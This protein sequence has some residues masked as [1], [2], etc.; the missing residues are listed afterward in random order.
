M[1]IKVRGKRNLEGTIKIKGAK[2]SA[3][4]IIPAAI[5]CDGEVTLHNVPHISDVEILLNILK[6]LDYFIDFKDGTLRIKKTKNFKKIIHNTDTG[7]MRGSYY[8]IGSFLSKYHKITIN[9]SGG[10]NL[11]LRPINYHL[12][13]FERLGVKYSLENNM[14]SLKA[15]SLKGARIDLPFPSVGATINIMLASTKAKGETIITGAAKEPEVIDTANF[16]ISMGAKIEGAGTDTI[17]IIGVKKLSETEYT[18]ASD[19]I[20]AGTFLI[21]GALS[22]GNGIV[23]ENV[24]AS[25]LTSLTDVLKEMGAKMLISPNKIYIRADKPLKATSITTGPYPLFPTDLGPMISVLLTQCHGTSYLTETVFSNRFS[26]VKDLIKM[27]AN[28][29]VNSNLLEINGPVKLEGTEMKAHDLRGAASLILAAAM[30]RKF[31]Y[32]ENIEILYR[33]YEKPFENFTSLGMQII[34]MGKGDT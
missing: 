33:G 30:S 24:D 15:K 23:V 5:L 31:S 9:S 16:L 28:I 8:F 32:I 29:K 7:K 22:R 13:G 4:A 11:G 6:E 20:E 1:K 3:V 19:R 17:K 10:C 18:I 14:L 12:D 21:L 27:G 26:Q 34:E 25:H 2:N